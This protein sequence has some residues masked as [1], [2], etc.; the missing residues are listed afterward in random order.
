MNAFRSV[1]L[2]C[3]QVALCTAT[4]DLTKMKLL[5]FAESRVAV[6]GL[7]TILAI[8][9]LPGVS[10][11]V[12]TEMGAEAKGLPT[13]VTGI[14]P[15]PTV[16]PLVLPLIGFL[17]EGLPTPAACVWLLTGVNS[18]VESKA[19]AL[20]EGFP[21]FL[22]DIRFFPGVSSPVSD[23]MGAQNEGFPTVPTCKGLLP[24]VDFLMLR[25]A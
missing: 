16:D 5:V 20:A 7:V 19:R 15:F 14:R 10:S 8:W 2:C 6:K 24:C 1:G 22:T 23:E 9:L 25:K 12:L 13:Y 3:H 21:T 17:G 18:T 11:P 4:C